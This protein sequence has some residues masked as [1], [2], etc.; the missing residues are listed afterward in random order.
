MS[1]SLQKPRVN[2]AKVTDARQKLIKKN[3]VAIRDAREK[4]AESQRS[5]IKDAR[6]LLSS[7]KKKVQQPIN[8]V[9]RAKI[10][11]SHGA[12]LSMDEELLVD[13]HD[14][15]IDLDTFKTKPLASLRRTVQNDNFRHRPAPA[16]PIPRMPSLPTFSIQNREPSPVL[17][18]PF[19]CYNVPTRR[20]VP[21]PPIPRSERF[22]AGRVMSAHMDA[23]EL[24]RKSI[25]R[26]S[27]IDDHDDRFES[28]RYVSSEARARYASNDSAGIFANT[29]IRRPSPPPISSGHRIIVSNLDQSITEGDIREL[30]EDIGV[31]VSSRIIRPGIAEVMYQNEGDAEI[32]LETYHNR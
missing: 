12:H 4:I 14:M 13:E 24:P 7:K 16:L 25:L 20:H 10:P 32:A 2:Q 3:R 18:D 29:N 28:D 21:P 26:P 1:K 5:T 22:Q 8:I 6:E 9:R 27:R 31:L 15:E 19:D 30:F 11:R 17:P 23:Y